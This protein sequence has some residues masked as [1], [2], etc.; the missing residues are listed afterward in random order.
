MQGMKAVLRIVG[1]LLLGL[2][3]LAG[4][5][6]VALAA[7]L[8][9][10]IDGAPRVSAA[11]SLT[12]AHIERA[13]RLLERNDPRTMRAGALRTITVSEEDLDL[14]V[15]YLANRFGKGS[16]KIELSDGKARAQA[17]I[18]LP[19]LPAIPFSALIF[20]GRYVN[21]DAA[22]SET[23][24]LPQFD[25]L[26]IG[27]MRIP[28]FIANRILGAAIGWLQRSASYGAATDTV[29]NVSSRNG[30]LSVVYQ[31]N[32][33]VPD[34]L[35]AALVPVADQLRMQAYQA[36]L[37]E[38]TGSSNQGA[39]L[40]ARRQTHAPIGLR[41]GTLVQALFQLA[42]QRGGETAAEHRAAIIV[43]AFYVNGKGLGAIIPAARHWTAPIAFG[44]TLADRGDFA[45]HFTISAALAA[46]AGSPLADAVGLYK[47]IDD[48]RGGSGFSFNDL[49]AD[50]AGTR[51][52]ELATGSGVDV[53]KI[54]RLLL[55]GARDADLLPEVKDLPE[56]L[57]EAE[58]KRR[59]GGI[60]APAY[61]KVMKD[62]EQRI[63]A[64][65]LYQ[66]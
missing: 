29:K 6:V 65:P 35:A 55:A 41:L 53:R 13:K 60:G 2:L 64:L 32:E 45:Q 56:F 57:Q 19:P 1:S 25:H 36:R 51:F 66:P 5:L 54:Q 28:A 21:I 9:L 58:F 17:S 52:G 62:I 59:Y 16:S 38:L 40:P 12:S 14:A 48:S 4:V 23:S 34:Q 33:A 30:M 3:G 46:T 26:K 8:Y 49:A 50:R 11:A 7:M 42:A 47:E 43:I 18:M 39:R 24:V 37:V 61:T 63:A 31:W 20:S 27:Q 22:F 44:V 15:N 10:A